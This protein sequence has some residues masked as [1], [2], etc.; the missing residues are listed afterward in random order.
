MKHVML[1]LE[2]LGT[3]PGSAVIS[4]GAVEFELDGSTGKTFHQ[5]ITAASCREI[6]LIEDP[7]THQWWAKQSKEAQERVMRDRK[8]ITDT[9]SRF[10][11]WFLS[12][13]AEF[14]WGN[15]STFDVVLWECACRKVGVSAPWKF[16][17]VRDMRT[18]IHLFDFDVR[19][20]KRV[21]VH[22][23][24]LDDAKF[25]VACV[26]AA[27]KKGRPAPINTYVADEGLFA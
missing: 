9:V 27:L 23:D 22:H 13:G 6:G 19:D 1:D 12:C 25:Q 18:V 21:G 3:I 16:W 10:G 24:A 7:A 15:G 4:V 20:M 11:S 2:T 26:A 8:P 5:N 14:V 17:N